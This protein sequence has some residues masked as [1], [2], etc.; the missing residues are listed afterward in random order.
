[1]AGQTHEHVRCTQAPVLLSLKA[2]YAKAAV[3]TAAHVVLVRYH[4]SKRPSHLRTFVH[5]SLVP[6]VISAWYAST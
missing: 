3:P 1:M 2:T 4:T 5:G 6:R